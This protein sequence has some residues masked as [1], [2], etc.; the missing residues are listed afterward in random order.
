MILLAD[1]QQNVMPEGE[2]LPSYCRERDTVLNMKDDVIK[3]ADLKTLAERATQRGV[4]C[5]GNLRSNLSDD[6]VSAP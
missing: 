5:H 3:F 1:V 2:C 6:S 4:D